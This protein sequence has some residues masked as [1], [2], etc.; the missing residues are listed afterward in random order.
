MVSRISFTVSSPFHWHD[1][2]TQAAHR[3]NM[4]PSSR[5]MSGSESLGAFS[6]KVRIS[7]TAG[8]RVRRW[9]FEVDADVRTCD[10]SVVDEG[11]VVCVDQLPIEHSGGNSWDAS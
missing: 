2:C 3:V 5:H 9:R 1:I 10:A 11:C 8:R 7:Q 6:S 4:S